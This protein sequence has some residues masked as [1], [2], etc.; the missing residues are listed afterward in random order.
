MAA[1]EAPFDW[2]SGIFKTTM[3]GPVH[4]GTIN[5][6]GDGQADLDNHGGPDRPVL[7]YSAEHYPFWRDTL[8][9]PELG[10]G[11]FGENFTVSGL[12]EETV[13]IG[14]TYQVGDVTFQISQ[15]RNPCW[16][17]SRRVGV[18]D[19]AAQ[20]ERTGK[21]GWYARVLVEGDVEANT[22]VELV[23]RPHPKFTIRYAQ[24][25]W[26]NRRSAMDPALELSQCP[27]LSADWRRYL[28]QVGV[29]DN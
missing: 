11:W 6:H 22:G 2:T 23:E 4:V 20:V 5:L 14:D 16:K 12:T 15:P 29:A 28:G 3:H 27:H 24:Q 26:K 10:H 9:R 17:L 18:F 13:C 19:L 7:L 21:S 25:V 1:E 8:M